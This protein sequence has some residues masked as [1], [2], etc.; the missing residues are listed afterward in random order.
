[1]KAAKPVAQVMKSSGVDVGS[2]E[3]RAVYTEVTLP[4][5]AAVTVPAST[6]FPLFVPVVGASTVRP[7]IMFGY[8]DGAVCSMIEQLLC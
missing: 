8:E 7:G 1:M 4:A 5:F 3:S 6:S 2:H